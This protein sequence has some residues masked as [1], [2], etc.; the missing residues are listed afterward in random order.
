[1]KTTLTA[2]VILSWLVTLAGIVALWTLMPLGMLV[3]MAG[4]W[5]VSYVTFDVVVQIWD[6]DN[7]CETCC[8]E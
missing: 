5:L 2:L 4:M 3:W 6:L 7:E 1:M 8:D